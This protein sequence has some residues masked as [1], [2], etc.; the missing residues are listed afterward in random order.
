MLSCSH[1]SSRPAWPALGL[2]SELPFSPARHGPS[3]LACSPGTRQA[4]SETLPHRDVDSG[5]LV[6]PLPFCPPRAKLQLG[7]F[8]AELSLPAGSRQLR[9]AALSPPLLDHANM[10]FC[11][12]LPLAVAFVPSAL[13][14]VT[15]RQTATNF[16][17]APSSLNFGTRGA[18]LNTTRPTGQHPLH[19]DSPSFNLWT[20]REKSDFIKAVSSFPD[21]VS[22]KGTF[23]LRSVLFVLRQGADIFRVKRVPCTRIRP[24]P[25]RCI[26]AST[27]TRT[28][29]DPRIGAMATS[30]RRKSKVSLQVGGERRRRADICPVCSKSCSAEQ[31]ASEW[32]SVEAEGAIRGERWRAGIWC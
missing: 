20:A 32:S 17:P 14:A 8:A 21:P 28:R 22:T 9:L 25:S 16:S 31:G 12:L 15:R 6:K 27:T 11:S 3:R 1:Q 4:L 26:I 10:R 24:S 13:A 23:K 30:R 29:A 19:G 18:S 2:Y 7:S 5:P